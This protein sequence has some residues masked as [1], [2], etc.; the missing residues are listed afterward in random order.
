MHACLAS[1]DPLVRHVRELI[2]HWFSVF[3]L[4]LCWFCSRL[5]S[6]SC[7]LV[8]LHIRERRSRN[9]SWAKL[10]GGWGSEPRHKLVECL[11]ERRHNIQKLSIM[12]AERCLK[13]PNG[14]GKCHVPESF[15]PTR[16]QNMALT[17]CNWQV[18]KTITQEINFYKHE[19]S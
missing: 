5:K 3:S 14:A 15:D 17:F 19:V 18:F 11:P 6:T 16:G 8:A 1:V 10:A 9:I 12:G 7:A 4:R 2:I 13:K